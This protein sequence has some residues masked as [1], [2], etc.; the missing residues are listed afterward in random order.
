VGHPGVSGS[1]SLLLTR[2]L[3]WT[4]IPPWFSE[5]VPRQIAR[6]GLSAAVPQRCLDDFGFDAQ[7]TVGAPNVTVSS[8]PIADSLNCNLWA[9]D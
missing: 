3:T 1:S 2:T 7:S 5:T 4:S 9:M 6:A 8:I